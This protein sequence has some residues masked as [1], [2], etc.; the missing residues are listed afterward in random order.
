MLYSVM[1]MIVKLYYSYALKF[2]FRNENGSSE[3]LSKAGMVGSAFICLFLALNRQR[4]TDL[5]EFKTSLVHIVSSTMT[6][7]PSKQTDKQKT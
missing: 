3:N 6:L 1:F 4:Q 5:C 7:P 2:S